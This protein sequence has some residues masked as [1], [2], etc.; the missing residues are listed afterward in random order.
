MCVNYTTT[1]LCFHDNAFNIT[2]LTEIYVRQKYKLKAV[3]HVLDDNAY[4]TRHGIIIRTLSLYTKRCN[5][6]LTNHR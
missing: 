5:I 1:L 3:L 2:L 6:Q 4:G